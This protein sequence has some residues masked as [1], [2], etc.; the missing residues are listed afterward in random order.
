LRTYAQESSSPKDESP[1]EEKQVRDKKKV[2]VLA[3]IGVIAVGLVLNW[4]LWNQKTKNT[5]E[6]A[7]DF[8]LVDVDGN[9]FTLSSHLGKVVVLNFMATWCGGCKSEIPELKSVWTIYNKTIV[10]VSISIAFETEEQIRTFR[11]SHQGATWIWIKDTA[12]VA[13]AYDVNLIPKTV[14]IDKNGFIA[15]THT[16]WVDSSTLI[17]E[18]EQL[19]G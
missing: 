16:G 17:S 19:L 5:G 6:P 11:D 14:I 18:I 9:N 8:S 7:P 4:P 15:F 3:V 12:D 2:L 13:K 1:K 10:M